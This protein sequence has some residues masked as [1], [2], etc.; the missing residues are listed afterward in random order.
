M[1]AMKEMSKAR[2]MAKNNIESVSK[3]LQFLKSFDN[4]NPLNNFIINVRYACHDQDNLFICLDLLKGGDLR[5]HLLKEKCFQPEVTQF[6]V[7]CTALALEACHLKKIIHRDLKPENLIFDERGYIKLTDFGIASQ[8]KKGL[9]NHE[10]QSGSPGYQAPEIMKNQS[11]ELVS[12]YFALGVIAAE[13]MTAKRPYRGK[14]KKQILDEM[15]KKQVVYTKEP[16]CV[17]E[18]YPDEALDFINNCIKLRP[19]DRLSRLE[20]VK[21]HPWFKNFDWDCLIAMKT[22]PLYVPPQNADNF[23]MNNINKDMENEDDLKQFILEL[24]D[25]DNHI[26]FKDYYYDQDRK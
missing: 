9:D 23:D 6:I 2:V 7:A 19:Q 22:Q 11:H 8:W 25:P 16:N 10:D 17:Y 24:K 15:L 26:Q 12:D 18:D 14:N 3:E 5:F 1:Y 20:N 13:C 21:A 4:S